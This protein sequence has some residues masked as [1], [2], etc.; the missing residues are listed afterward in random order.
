MGASNHLAL[1][2]DELEAAQSTEDGT[3]AIANHDTS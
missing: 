3:I 2:E 1:L